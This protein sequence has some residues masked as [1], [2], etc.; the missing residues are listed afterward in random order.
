MQ[1][2]I[3]HSAQH[4]IAHCSVGDW[5]WSFELTS[6]YGIRTALAARKTPT[7]TA[8]TMTAICH[9]GRPPPP[10]APEDCGCAEALLTG[11]GEGTTA[12]LV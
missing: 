10:P 6:R 9:P 8:T 5:S 3:I 1:G 12:P 2:S 7:M 4:S 11:A